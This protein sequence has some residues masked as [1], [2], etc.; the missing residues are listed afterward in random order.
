MSSSLCDAFTRASIDTWHRIQEGRALR[1]PLGEETLTDLLLRDLLRL[2]LPDITIKAFTKKAEGKNGADWEW[3]FQ[4]YT[5]NWLGLRVQAKVIAHDA[6]EFKHLHY[7]KNKGTPPQRKYQCDKLITNAAASHKW[8]CVPVYC[9]YSYWTATHTVP[10]GYCCWGPRPSASSFG[11]SVVPAT[12]VRA[13]RAADSTGR[14][15]RSTLSD[16][17]Q[18]SLPLACLVCCPFGPGTE[19]VAERMHALLDAMGA[20]QPELD[21]LRPT[22]PPYVQQLTRERR[23]QSAVRSGI[24]NN[25]R[26]DI[27]LPPGLA[28]VVAIQQTSL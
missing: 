23:N 25:F 11:C 14:D 18:Y 24:D 7:Y 15:L 5:G 10:M 12:D 4:G 16:T 3:W 13:L 28:G 22:P 19:S 6:D 21:Y 9:L 17:L 8:P 26:S 20:L 27:Q 1:Y 2:H